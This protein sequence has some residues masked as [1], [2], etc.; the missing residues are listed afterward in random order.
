MKTVIISLLSFFLGCAVI[1]FY[2]S[3][4]SNQPV[5]SFLSQPTPAPTPLAVY[6][7]ENLSKI[8]FTPSPIVLDAVISETPLYRQQLFHF[9]FAPRP[10]DSTKKTVT[11]VINVPKAEGSYPVLLMMRGYAPAETYKPGIGT[12]PS[13]S[14]F[15]SHG[16]ITIAPDFLGFGG[17][18]VRSTDAY[19]SRFQTYTTALSLLASLPNVNDA[20]NA[21]YSGR[22]KADIA[23]I[24]M[25]GHSNGGHIVLSTLAI[26]R[27][28][29]PTVLWAP[30]S[31]SFPYS[32]L[33]Y[34]DEDDDGGKEHRGELAGFEMLYDTHLFDPAAY[35]DRIRAPLQIHQGTADVEVPFWWSDDLVRT[36]KKNGNDVDYHMYPGSDH[37]LRP[38]WNDVVKK[39]LSFYDTHF[40]E[41]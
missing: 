37:N 8:S 41:K 20:L 21:S 11:G 26:S 35:Y 9:S 17:S 16:Y 34:T 12:Q 22:I 40:I 2:F 10:G 24:G 36:L 30:V 14:V 13:A 33:A 29:Y 18:D 32:V 31:K 39:S 28:N 4:Q 15:A 1:A 27:A 23:K 6:E 5:T 3:H 38:A 19:E 25:W 7:F